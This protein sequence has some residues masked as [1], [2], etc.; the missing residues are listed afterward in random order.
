MYTIIDEVQANQELLRTRLAGAI[1]E[2]PPGVANEALPSVPLIDLSKSFSSDL[3]DRQRVASEIREA[4]TTSG[5]FQ[6][7]NHGIT[8]S[9]IVDVLGQAELFFKTLTPEEKDALHI[10]HS[11]LFRGYEAGGDTYVNPDDNS[12]AA[13]VE[14]KEGGFY[15]TSF[16]IVQ[17]I[18]DRRDRL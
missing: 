7:S 6:I 4:C 2:P 1:S 10:R 12:A 17:L 5:F 9:A 14:T 15:F 18:S 13:E 8:N 3:A 16:L 11:Q